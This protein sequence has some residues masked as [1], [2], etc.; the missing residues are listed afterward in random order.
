[1]KSRGL[2]GSK[3]N[4]EKLES[5]FLHH[6]VTC[7]VKR[8]NRDMRW[9]PAISHSF[10]VGEELNWGNNKFNRKRTWQRSVCSL[11]NNA[12]DIHTYIQITSFFVA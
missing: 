2:G 7:T 10:Y 9:R 8:Q 5:L 4:N 12:V 1:M 3:Q 11:P 6:A